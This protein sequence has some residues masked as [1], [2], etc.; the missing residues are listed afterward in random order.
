L[1]LAVLALATALAAPARAD[2]NTTGLTDEEIERRMQL[3]HVEREQVRLV[4]VP[5]VVTNGRGRVVRGLE[6]SDFVL[7]EDRV[8]QTIRYV[9]TEQDAPLSIAFLLDVS[10]SMRHVGKL[11]ESKAAIR[12][13]VDGLRAEDQIGLVCFADEQVDWITEF[14]D[15]RTRFLR[16][17]DVQEGYGQTALIDALARAPGLVDA[18]DAGTKAIV[19]FTDGVDTAS[20]M[21]QFEALTTARGVNVPIY[22]VGFATF[23][24]RLLPRGST[25]AEHR[26]VRLFAEETG[27]RLFLVRDPDDLKEAVIE[28][29]RELRFRYV[30]SYVPQR[31]YWDGTFRR[32]RLE[33]VGR[34]L[35]VRARKGYYAQP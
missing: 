10:G 25:P 18:R 33:T 16:R 12:V 35:N 13:F 27:G 9:R 4:Q 29:Q 28:I 24:S 30:V 34:N 14:T 8:P 20:T 11:D 6:P 21:T 2:Q 7:Y 15:D 17:L 5:A 22:A 32:I 3:H 26:T 31:T 1:G 23:A 19:L